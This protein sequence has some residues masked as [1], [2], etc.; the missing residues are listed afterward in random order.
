MNKISSSQMNS[1]F[2]V[3]NSVTDERVQFV[4]QLQ[5]QWWA[6]L[7]VKSVF[8]HTFLPLWRCYIFILKYCL[9]LSFLAAHYN[10]APLGKQSFIYNSSGRWIWWWAF[11]DH[12]FFQTMKYMCFTVFLWNRNIHVCMA[13]SVLFLNVSHES[14]TQ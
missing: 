11:M 7:L 9:V 5:W 4:L 3:D 14:L 8:N 13:T 12:N 1:R 6:P 10:P 2:K